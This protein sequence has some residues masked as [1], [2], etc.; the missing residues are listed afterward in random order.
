MNVSSCQRARCSACNKDVR[1]RKSGRFFVHGPL[2][3][4]CRLSDCIP[5]SAGSQTQVSATA[6]L[7]NQASSENN[8]RLLSDIMF[9]KGRIL[10]FVPHGARVQWALTLTECIDRILLEP[11][12]Q[13]HWLR[14]MLAPSLCLKKPERGG[15]SRKTS[16]AGIVNKQCSAFRSSS[17]LYSLAASDESSQRKIH[18]KANDNSRLASAVSRKLDEADI[19]GAVRLLSTTDTIAPFDAVTLAKLQEKH[20]PRPNDRKDFPTTDA[21][22]LQVSVIE[23]RSAVKSFS[24]GSAGGI[25]GLRPQHLKDALSAKAC[26]ANGNFEVSLTRL[27]NYILLGNIPMSVQ[28]ILFGAAITA[29]IKKEGGVRPIAVGEAIRRLCAK[30]ATQAIRDRFSGVFAPLQIGFGIPGGAEAAVHATRSFVEQASQDEVL[31]KIDF[32]NA[33][34]TMRRDHVAF[35]MREAAPELLP[36]FSLSYENDSI[37]TFGS[38]SLS[39]SE[40]F[41]QGDPLAVFGFCLGLHKE[42]QHL[43]SR[44]CVSYIDDVTLGGPAETVLSDLVSFKKATEAIGLRINPNKCEILSLDT[45]DSRHRTLQSFRKVCPDM[46]ETSRDNLVFLGSPIGPSAMN[47]TLSEKIDSFSLLRNRLNFIRRHD[48]FFLLRNCFAI[49]K[50]LYTFRTAPTFLVPTL[51]EDIERLLKAAITDV[52][53]TAFDDSR[54]KQALLPSRDGGLGIPSPQVIAVGAYLASVYASHQLTSR[55]LRSA[56]VSYVG[57]ATTSWRQMSNADPPVN[58]TRQRSWTQPIFDRQWNI[59]R[60]SDPASIPRLLGCRAPGAGDWLNALPS[61]PLGLRMDNEQFATAIAL[62]LGAPVCVSHTCVCGAEVERSAQHPLVCSKMKSRHA[63]HRLGNDV[64][65]RALKSAEVPATLE[66]LGLS[67]C[68]GKRPDGSS[69]LAWKGGKPLVWDFTC[70]H[71]L[72]ASY[73]HKAKQDGSSIATAAEIKKSKK[74]EDLAPQC[75]FQPVAVETLGGLGEE[76]LSFLREVGQR[77]TACTSDPRATTHLRQRLAVAVQKGNAACIRE[78]CDRSVTFAFLSDF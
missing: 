15:R 54:W 32:S 28:P 25:S 39:S 48:A 10:R 13:S 33:F 34:N 65:F 44:F 70:V 24:A 56:P 19:K 57:E 51:L 69:L 45:N 38:D 17:D 18:K 14:L 73:D 37:L 1:L 12:E 60:D 59:L 31:L 58:M 21:P 42:L 35:C 53:N 7:A 76:T 63:R 50:M 40:G 46:C 29:F 61:G 23:V 27:V 49:P 9:F 22:P 66:P 2:D 30:C 20:P 75:V 5:S 74:Y 6:V 52:T 62:R 68:D 72:A 36:F 67:R 26:G 47:S 55:I 8:N 3:A 4:R 77:I 43:K 78:S 64:I 71:R 11:S 16:L 41:Q